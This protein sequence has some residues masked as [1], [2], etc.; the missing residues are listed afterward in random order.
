MI[1]A[2][3]LDDIGPRCEARLAELVARAEGE[4]ALVVCLT[5]SAIPEGGVE[6]FGES[7]P[8]P[9]YNLDPTTM[10]TML[11]AKTGV[12]VLDNG[13]IVSKHN[14]RDADGL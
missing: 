8:I 11:R 13:I 10:Q 12:V 1:C 4:G 14:C 2:L 5:S 9:V 3:K 7:A 6:R